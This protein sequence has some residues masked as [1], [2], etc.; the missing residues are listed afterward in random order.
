MKRESEEGAIPL[1]LAHIGVEK[2]PLALEGVWVA[3]DPLKNAKT[4][5]RSLASPSCRRSW[6]NAFAAATA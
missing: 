6:P 2:N 1:T 5:L 4:N 3:L